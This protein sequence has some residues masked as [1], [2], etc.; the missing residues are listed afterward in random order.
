MVMDAFRRPAMRARLAPMITWA[1]CAGDG[2]ADSSKEG[3][4][5]SSK[6][7]I[8]DSSKE[9]IADSGEESVDPG[10]RQRVINQPRGKFHVV[11]LTVD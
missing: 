11:K 8:T 9:G 7:G 1:S 3:I 2:V 10:D 5:D 6:E 4:T